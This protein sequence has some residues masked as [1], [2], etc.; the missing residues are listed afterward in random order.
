MKRLI[1][2]KKREKLVPEGFLTLALK[3]S[4]AVGAAAFIKSPAELLVRTDPSPK[5]V[6]DFQEI[7]NDFQK[8]AVMFVVDYMPKGFLV[9]D[10]QPQV[11]LTG[12]NDEPVL[13]GAVTGEDFNSFVKAGST[14][15]PEFFLL[16]SLLA[17]KFKKIFDGMC[18]GDV[19]KLMD[20]LTDPLYRDEMQHLTGKDFNITLLGSNGE[21]CSWNRNEKLATYDWGTTSNS[22]G[23]AEGTI[24][25]SAEPEKKKSWMERGKE[26]V[27][28]AT[29]A[30]Q[31][32][33]EAPAKQPEKPAGG[34]EIVVDDDV[35]NPKPQASPLPA[36]VP[37][38]DPLAAPKT[39]TAKVT[40]GPE[41][42][43]PK[44]G[45]SNKDKKNFYRNK[46]KTGVIPQNWDSCPMVELKPRIGLHNLKQAVEQNTKKLEATSDEIVVEDTDLN[47]ALTNAQKIALKKQGKDTSTKHVNV[48]NEDLQSA[49]P[50]MSDTLR[51][52]FTDKFVKPK[53]IGTSHESVMNPNEMQKLEDANPTFCEQLGLPN[54][55]AIEHLAYK[56]LR[57]MTTTF[58]AVAAVLVRNLLTERFQRKG[59]KT[60]SKTEEAAD[61]TEIVAQPPKKRY[62]F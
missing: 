30:T 40:E 29:G 3:G 20:E 4:T 43:A 34:D 44:M 24:K 12:K 11:L 19:N 15:N 28:N 14:H 36:Q 8:E 9:D 5:T 52:E 2:V 37:K 41:Y 58:P 22:L 55:D 48:S 21:F 51:Q 38:A 59:A 46:S 49:R 62:A 13:A 7:Q 57:E 47:P 32:V 1:F 31:V 61:K 54:L 39:D 56:D 35:L 33:N 45:W 27:K 26:L 18:G 25:T 10:L 50:I 53:Q 6:Q 23:Y 17:P 16:N 60:A 42:G